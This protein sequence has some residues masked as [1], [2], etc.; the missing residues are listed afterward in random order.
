MKNNDCGPCAKKKKDCDCPR[1]PRGPAGA[2]GPSGSTGPSGDPGATGPSGD[3]GPAARVT[4]PIAQEIPSG[5]ST[6]LAFTALRDGSDP[7]VFD[8]GAPTRLTAPVAGWYLITGSVNWEPNDDGL[9]SLA[10]EQNDSTNIADVTQPALAGEGVS[11]PQSISTLWYLAAGEF[12]ELVVLQD[13]G[14]TIDV[15]SEADFSPEFAMAR[16]AVGTPPAP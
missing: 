1:G 11:T 7:D 3:V 9:R 8:A 6:P 12:V 4:N 5:T 2:T 10:I 15:T 13:S 14:V 16:V